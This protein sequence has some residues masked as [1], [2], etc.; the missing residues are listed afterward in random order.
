MDASGEY[1]KGR[2]KETSHS[3]KEF[4]IKDAEGDLLRRL[5]FKRN[6][7]RKFDKLEEKFDA[8][9]RDLASIG[10][11]VN[12]F[13][14]KVSTFRSRINKF[15]SRVNDFRSKVADFAFETTEFSAGITGLNATLDGSSREWDDKIVE[16]DDKIVEWGDKIEKWSNRIEKWS[17]KGEKWNKEV[18]EW[19][20]RFREMSQSSS[21]E[22]HQPLPERLADWGRLE[23]G[24]KTFEEELPK[25]TLSVSTAEQRLKD[26]ISMLE[27]TEEAVSTAEHE[28]TGQQET[29]KQQNLLMNEMMEKMISF[30]L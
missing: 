21:V 26:K 22:K 10:D 27:R 17:K 23:S 9:W 5:L 28:L 29:L 24:L 25:L 2:Q 12:D 7:D 18:V 1:P 13:N 30:G 6:M 3:E 16:W 4:T 8:R 20:K 19:D 15:K 14:S 11:R